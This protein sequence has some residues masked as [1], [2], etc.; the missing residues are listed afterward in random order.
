MRDQKGFTFWSLAFTIVT[1]VFFLILG[2]KLVP[3]Y[4]EYFTIKKAL[5]TL[6]SNGSLKT[7]SKADIQTSFNHARLIDNIK[8]V[9]ADDLEIGKDD[10]GNTTVSVEYQVKVPMVA[11]ITALLDFAASTDEAAGAKT[12]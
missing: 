8:S 9:T 5:T 7:M 4:I 6:K 11:N 2:M 1:I 12:E 10:A 3:S